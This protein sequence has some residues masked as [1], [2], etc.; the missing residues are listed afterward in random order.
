MQSINYSS[1]VLFGLMAVSLS[2]CREKGNHKSRSDRNVTQSD[3]DIAQPEAPLSFIV[4]DSLEESISDSEQGNKDISDKKVESKTDRMQKRLGEVE[5]KIKR[6][7]A[8]LRRIY[9]M[10]YGNINIAQLR[11]KSRMPFRK[12]VNLYA[13]LDDWSR[14]FEY[15]APKLRE[16]KNQLNKL[17]EKA[18]LTDQEINHLDLEVR[19]YTREMNTKLSEHSIEQAIN[20]IPVG[21]SILN[22]KKLNK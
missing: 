18:S 10:I 11:K 9:H 17:K 13:Q 12:K 8:T 16:F 5:Q 22:K 20:S 2:S 15:Y 3:E 21:S 19:S 6:Y 14:S 4:A 7:H 1:L